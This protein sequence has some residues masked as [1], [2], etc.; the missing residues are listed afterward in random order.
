DFRFPETTG[1]R[2]L[3]IKLIN[4]YVSLVHKA[5]IRDEEVCKAFL[6]VMGLIEPPSILLSPKILWRTLKASTTRP[7][8]KNDFAPSFEVRIPAT[9]K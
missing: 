9:E 5:T 4:R 3:G 8:Q 2:P 1:T 6:K 7:S